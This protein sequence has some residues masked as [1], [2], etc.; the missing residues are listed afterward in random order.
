MTRRLRWRSVADAVRRLGLTK[1]ATCHTFWPLFGC[2]NGC[3][4]E[5]H[6]LDEDMGDDGSTNPGM[7]PEEED[8]AADNYR[9]RLKKLG[10]LPAPSDPGEVR[11]RNRE[12]DEVERRLREHEERNRGR[13]SQD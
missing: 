8:A 7:T 1:L 2:H 4:S 3:F 10:K 6:T 13:A 5:P 12:R 11:A 9:E